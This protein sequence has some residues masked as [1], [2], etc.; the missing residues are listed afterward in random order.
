MTSLSYEI[1]RDPFRFDY[2]PTVYFVK[3]DF[4][5]MFIPSQLTLSSLCVLDIWVLIVGIPYSMFQ[6]MFR[7][8]HHKKNQN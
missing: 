5:Y 1:S 8:Q 4:A 2:G 7:E 6:L 3:L